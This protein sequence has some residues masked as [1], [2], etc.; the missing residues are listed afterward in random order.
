M[1]R[2]KEGPRRQSAEKTNRARVLRQHM[3][4]AERCL[5]RVLQN[6]NISGIKFRRQ[7]P[8]GPYYLD[9][10]SAD[11]KMAIELDGGQHYTVQGKKRDAQRD[12][13]VQSLGIKVI[14]YS[15]R[16]VLLHLEEVSEEIRR[17]LHESSP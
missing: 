8:F 10:Y 11:A 3:T 17:Y 15:D 4:D 14:R 7:V 2:W 13:Y 16:D 5:W 6:R 12:A 9:F 1:V